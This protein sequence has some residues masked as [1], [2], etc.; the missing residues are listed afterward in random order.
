MKSLLRQHRYALGIALQRLARQPFSSLANLCIMALALCLPLLGAAILDAARPVTRDLSVT[1]EV[2]VF[3]Q[4]GTPRDASTKTLE[5]VRREN[6]AEIQSARLV[7]K[8]NALAALQR[9]PGWRDALAVLPDNPLPDAI[10]VTFAAGPQATETATQLA[11]QW[12]S[13][14]GVDRV[15][16]DSD[17]MQ[18]LEALASTA[19]I[20]L[21][22]L[23]IAVGLVVL[24]TVFNTVRM[25]ALTQREEIAVAR[26]VGATESFVRRPFLYQGALS[27]L[28]ASLLA[29]VFAV[30]ALRPMNGALTRLAQS[31]NTTITLQLPAVADLLPA[32]VI[33][34]AL[35]ALAARWSV[36]RSTRF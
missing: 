27:G 25:Q 22:L 26:L 15:Q 18:R 29:I 10:T 6:G 5:R 13:W 23:A 14:P 33:T 1:P 34:A 32:I 24:A 4:V 19:R 11:Q 21:L 12:Q 2:T 8:E 28:L 31:Y 17:W 36:T 20:A 35:C 16:L 7:P 30:F 3:M 9:T